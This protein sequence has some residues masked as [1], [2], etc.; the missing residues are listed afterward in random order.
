[1]AEFPTDFGYA[2]IITAPVVTAEIGWVYVPQDMRDDIALMEKLILLMFNKEG[3]CIGKLSGYDIRL[4]EFYTDPDIFGALDSEDA[5]LSDEFFI[6]QKAMYPGK[7]TDDYE[8]N[9]LLYEK[10]I[11]KLQDSDDDWHLYSIFLCIDVNVPLKYRKEKVFTTMRG[12]LHG[13]NGALGE[14][15]CLWSESK[16]QIRTN[17]EIA[18]KWDCLL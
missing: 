4:T 10:Y 3:K 11:E 5:S 2:T 14:C 15:Y 16:K 7:I 8:E 18:K 17:I 1:M 9:D 6:M 12:L 13:W